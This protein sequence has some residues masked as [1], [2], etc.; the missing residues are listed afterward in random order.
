[1]NLWLIGAIG[2]AMCLFL[3][4]AEEKHQHSFQLMLAHSVLAMISFSNYM[5]A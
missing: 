4:L 2:W 1:M 3:D 5:S